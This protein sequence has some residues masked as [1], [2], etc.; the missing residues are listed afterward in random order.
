MNF[1][2]SFLALLAAAQ[3]IAAFPFGTTGAKTAL[4]PVPVT[5]LTCDGASFMCTA[6][7]D[8][9]DGNWVAQWTSPVFHRGN[10]GAP[11]HKDI[12]EQM[13]MA[14]VPVTELTCDG[15][16]FLCT[17]N[18]DFG[19]GN[20]VAQWPANVFH[21]GFHPGGRKLFAPVPVTDLNCDGETFMCT[22]NLDFADGNWKAQ[23]NTNVFHN[24]NFFKQN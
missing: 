7:L 11:D 10:F 8:F 22:G 3:S 2:A 14:P 19:D 23:W 24:N 15:S 4:A 1:T 17:A 18:L 16:S 5:K 13:A 21:S 20:W 9:A 6:N 12:I